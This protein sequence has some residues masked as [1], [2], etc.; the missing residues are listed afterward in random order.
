MD[1]RVYF[2]AILTIVEFRLAIRQPMCR[3]LQVDGILTRDHQY[4]AGLAK[5]DGLFF[6]LGF[7]EGCILFSLH[8]YPVI[9]SIGVIKDAA[10]MIELERRRNQCEVKDVHADA[11]ISL[12]GGHT[13]ELGDQ[14]LG[15]VVPTSVYARNLHQSVP[16]FFFLHISHSV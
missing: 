12:E 6:I 3:V 7:E 4:A 5:D 13:E 1:Y 15:L 9:G 10:P 14:S 11:L 16:V 8:Y 2:L